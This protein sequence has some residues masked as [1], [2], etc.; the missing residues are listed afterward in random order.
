MLVGGKAYRRVMRAA[1][2]RRIRLGSI[3]ADVTIA[4]TDGAGIGYQRAQLGA[5]LRSMG[6]CHA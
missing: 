2:E 6:A 1:I 3:P 5:Y 4:E